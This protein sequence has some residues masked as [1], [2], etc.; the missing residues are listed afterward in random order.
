MTFRHPAVTVVRP[1]GVGFIFSARL[2]NPGVSGALGFAD[3]AYGIGFGYL[4]QRQEEG[5]T[6]GRAHRLAAAVTFRVTAAVVVLSSS[7][8]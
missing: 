7:G 4:P 3:P 6:P 8:S 1:I 2:Y 5:R